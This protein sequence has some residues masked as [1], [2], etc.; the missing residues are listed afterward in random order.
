M[1]PLKLWQ[2]ITDLERAAWARKYSA[3]QVA[4]KAI[5]DALE[6]PRPAANLESASQFRRVVSQLWAGTT[7]T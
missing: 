6:T 5:E 4:R 2:L 7:T 1:E 3:V